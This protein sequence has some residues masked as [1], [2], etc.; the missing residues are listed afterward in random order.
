MNKEGN[1]LMDQNDKPQ[2]KMPN[3][4]VELPYTYL[5]AQYVMHYPL[6][7]IVVTASEGFMPFVQ[8]LENLSWIHY[9]MFF[10]QRTILSGSNY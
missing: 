3:P 6:L 4:S 1:P 7:M 8:R 10:V 5:M 2:L 9:Y